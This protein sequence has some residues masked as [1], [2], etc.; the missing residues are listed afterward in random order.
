MVGEEGGVDLFVFRV[1]GVGCWMGEE[2]EDL[3]TDGAGF[4]A[5]GEACRW[6]DA[7]VYMMC[8]GGEARGWCFVV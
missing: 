3:S 7:V 6:G 8:C 5:D 4:A 2:G 1:Q